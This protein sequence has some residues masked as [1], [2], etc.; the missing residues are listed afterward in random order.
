MKRFIPLALF[1]LTLLLAQPP[2]G[3]PPGGGG[4]ASGDG[5]W[6]RN[7]AFGELETFDYCNGH[8]P[9]S[10]TYHHHINPICLRAQ[11]NDNVTVVSTGRLGTLY[12][13][14]TSGFTHSPI[15]G[16][17]NDGYPVYGPYGYSDPTNAKSAVRRMQSSFSLRNITQRHTLP[18]WILPY[19]PNDSQTLT[20]L[21]YGPD[22]SAAYPL[23]R[24]VDDYDYIAGSGDL[25]QY[26]GRFT[27]TP[28]YPNG[29]YAYFVTIDSTGA[30]AYPFIINLQFYG[31]ASGGSTTTVASDAADYFTNG[32]V[33]GAASTDPTLASWY[34]KGSLKDAEAI[35]G[36]DPSLG[37][38]A[39][40]PSTTPTGVTVSGGQSAAAL[41][42]AQRVRYDASAVYINSNNLPSYVIGPWFEGD[43][44]G[45]VFMN[46]P[47]S[48]TVL[49]KI[50]R[51]PSA[52]T[53]KT[54][55]GM[56]SVGVWVNGVAIFNVLD[57]A[58]YSNSAAADESGGIVSNHAVQ[59]S[60]ASGE[61]GPLAV[62][63]LITAYPEFS[64]VLATSTASASSANWPLTL[65][66]TTVTVT[67]ST[68]ATFSA[69]IS[70]AS[71]TQVNYRM[72]PGAAT[73]LGS[74][75][76]TAGGTTVSGNV[77]IVATYPSIFKQTADGLAAA[78]LYNG[79]YATVTSAPISLANGPWYL[80]LY[81][82]GI[83]SAATTATINGV[84]A[85]V[86]YS[87]AEGVYPGL[88]Q[89]NVL[90]PASLAGAG[91]ATVVLTSAGKVSNQVY[92]NIQ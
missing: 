9:G 63:S 23:G 78:Q 51:S 88:D 53:T 50:P 70:Y 30:P 38:S 66:G 54:A 61:R 57:G 75:A 92:I 64:A 36:Y 42:D 59:V 20:T 17:A 11:L 39:T 2:G 6:L 32:A 76:F 48:Q 79:T 18:T 29:T 4:G 41:A 27:V 81:G 55:S 47:S 56:G 52:A 24:Y 12:A 35:T 84:N 90:I 5:I 19:L 69:Q 14:K 46:F 22:V 10:G 43:M 1:P 21:Q 74:V 62:G 85:T 60:A 25:D 68:K 16:W 8:Q 58:S 82:T 26:N 65:G 87:G 13:E 89:V 72:P 71:P 49:T 37:P 33:V 86:Q 83:G 44:T 34:T 40:W 28:D 77:N 31:T 3:G 91:K 15:L 73:G 67:D 80:I 7:A 45:G